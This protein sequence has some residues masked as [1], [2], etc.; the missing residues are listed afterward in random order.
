VT[1]PD[2]ALI[3]LSTV[4]NETVLLDAIRAGA[5]EALSIPASSA[6]EFRLAIDRAMV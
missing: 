5:H 1:T 6:Q 4:D 3:A 2:S